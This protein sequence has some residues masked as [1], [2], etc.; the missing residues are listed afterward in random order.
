MIRY[1]LG[2]V[3]ACVPLATVSNLSFAGDDKWTQFYFDA[4]P[5]WTSY[6]NSFTA[7][8]TKSSDTSSI[9]F[10]L[11]LGVNFKLWTNHFWLGLALGET[12]D[13]SY[14]GGTVTQVQV[15]LSPKYYFF[16]DILSGPCLRG[17]LGL[18][19]INVARRPGVDSL[20]MWGLGVGIGAGYEIPLSQRWRLG[21]GLNGVTRIYQGNAF[22]IVYPSILISF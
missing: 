2:F 13:T 9:S 17:E 4:G 22:L 19:Q 15:S 5:A 10:G 6:P 16:N 18:A 3:I 11:D 14:S 21:L 20:N 8:G 12:I 1:L 7:A